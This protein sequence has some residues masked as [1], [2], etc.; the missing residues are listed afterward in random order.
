M[1]S[2]LK[3]TH[4]LLILSFFSINIIAQSSV[5]TKEAV[6]NG[7]HLKDKTKDGLYGISLDQ[8]YEFLKGKKSKQVVVAIL[9]TG[10]DT[11]HEDL[12]SVLWNN[13]KEIPGN[14][15]DDDKNGY[16]DDIH[17]WNFVG[18]KDGKN[19]TKDSYERDRVYH[20]YKDRFEGKEIKV[21]SLSKE[22]REIYK[23]WSKAKAELFDEDE[24]SVDIL[25]Y[26]MAY[27]N[28]EKADSILKKAMGKDIYTG[29]ELEKFS[30]TDYLAKRS[31]NAM[32]ELMKAN[33]AMEI[34]NK[35]YMEGFKD[36]IDRE[37]QKAD[38]K[39][40]AP[41]D[42]RGDIVKDDYDDINDRFYG[43]NDIMG[44][45]AEHGT[46][47]AGI[48]A[49][50]RNNKIGI[51]GIAD[52]VKIM[53]VR[54]LPD[55]DEHDKDVAL[56]IRYAVDNGAQVI[57]MSFGKY[58]SPEKKWVDD[59]VQYAQNKGVLLVSAAGN[60]GFNADSV[61]HYP[62]KYLNIG[63][64]A[65]NWI[66][67][68]ANGDPREGNLVADFSN[69]GKQSVDVFAPG[70]KIYS[71]LPGGNQYGNFSGTSMASPVVAGLAALILEY[72]PTLSAE[73]VK[74]VIEKSAVSPIIEVNNPGTDEKV[75]FSELCKSGGI[76]N[77]YQALKLASTLKG[78]RITGTQL[79][80]F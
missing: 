37:Q 54:M 61:M 4:L 46:H 18:G 8:A 26:K 24:E 27:D 14:G 56:A 69:Y 80:A 1:N 66:C 21:D 59:A 71:T 64:V 74:F 19:V 45:F 41:P 60:E 52:N 49:G 5:E 50:T 3:S 67:V 47:L 34:T 43:N 31:R 9:D 42:Y 51:D 39:Q 62:N 79:K 63:K 17:G 55:G 44:Q 48:I 22:D 28:L 16:I 2:V 13:P 65:T 36:F 72:Y 68:G 23:M 11:T 53:F 57:N 15:K 76:V 78:Q 20:K 29:I 38:A 30:T 35:E 73:Q 33:E 12:R 58:F 25:L 40:F 75:K 6:P 32:L 70:V 10:V 77:A 7:W